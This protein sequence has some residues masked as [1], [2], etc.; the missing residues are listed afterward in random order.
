[1]LDSLKRPNAAMPVR[2]I[3]LL[4]AILTAVIAAA[5]SRA[6]IASGNQA[7]DQDDNDTRGRVIGSRLVGSTPAPAP[8]G[9]PEMA[10]AASLGRLAEQIPETEKT[11][12]DGFI[13]GLSEAEADALYDITD[14]LDGFGER[15]L[16]ANF[17]I[18]LPTDQRDKMLKLLTDID[19]RQRR[20]YAQE[21]QFNPRE[22]WYVVPEYL[23][24][25]GQSATRALMFGNLLCNST[26]GIDAKGQVRCTVPPG[27]NEFLQRWNVVLV[28][29]YQQY[30]GAFGAVAP[31]ELAPWQ[32]RIFKS[33]WAA[34]PYSK[35][36]KEREFAK[37]GR[38]L[39]DYERVHDCG[40]SL[41][42]PGW[43]L[44]AAH[45]IRLPQGSTRI[46]DIMRQRKVR[47]GTVDVGSG[48]GTEWTIDGIIVH[49]AANVRLP[50]Q[51]NDLAL[52]HIVGPR[53]A[54]GKASPRAL[55][56]AAPIRVAGPDF[57]NPSPFDRVYVTGWG[58]SG[59]A[60]TTRQLRDEHGTALA[61]QRYLQVATLRYLDPERC[62]HD[63]SFIKSGYRI[64][65][66]Q[67]CAGGAVTDSACWGDSGGPLVVK[68]G[69]A[70]VLLG[71]VSY[72]IG[73][74]RIRAPSAF[75][76]VRTHADWIEDA[77]KHFQRGKVVTWPP[78]KGEPKW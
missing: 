76:D 33:G 68:D 70:F 38:N 21:L 71:V 20:A 23:A 50:Q 64:R 47:L 3:L 43:I 67:V 29:W 69:S 49:G 59:H 14:R 52:L 78:A 54:P 5:P 35:E 57:G 53:P 51:G 15:G 10:R 7:E 46:E 8:A 55:V 6:Q 75:V 2:L 24:T 37:Y 12:F 34:R 60:D 58:L 1:M 4:A 32:A 25:A 56:K 11:A 31:H 74:G 39:L 28:R 72:G 66:G 41:I 17:L 62:N 73:C 42:R 16:F 40:G 18:G 45:C 36:E 65:P 13:A 63:A 22:N 77:P 48:G 27:A 61:F 9:D 26:S 44:T 19:Q 30:G